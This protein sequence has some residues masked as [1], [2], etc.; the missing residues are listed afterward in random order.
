MRPYKEFIRRA[1][2]GL[3]ADRILHSVNDFYA[4]CQ[5]L[6][7]L[8]RELSQ[9]K[10]INDVS[11]DIMGEQHDII[12]GYMDDEKKRGKDSMRIYDAH[13]KG[14]ESHDNG[15]STGGV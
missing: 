9:L 11:A 5:D 7:K 15:S 10:Q 13:S 8:E 12:L 6:E 2:K 4:L 1:R 3:P 14:G